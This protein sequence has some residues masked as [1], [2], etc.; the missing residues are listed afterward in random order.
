MYVSSAVQLHN[1]IGM[2][3]L[4]VYPT[5]ELWKIVCDSYSVLWYTAFP[6]Y[7]VHIILNIHCTVN[8]V[9]FSVYVRLYCVRIPTNMFSTPK[10]QIKA[11]RSTSMRV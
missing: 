4:C 3:L 1:V 8:K 9:V 5:N 2:A 10:R 6:P 11:V 7:A